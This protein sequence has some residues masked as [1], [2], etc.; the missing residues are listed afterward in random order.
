MSVAV[1]PPRERLRVAVAVVVAAV[2]RGAVVA[3]PG[4]SVEASRGGAS[5]PV[6]G[7]IVPPAPGGRA[8]EAPPALVAPPAGAAPPVSVLAVV[9]VVLLLVTPPA[10]AVVGRP[11]RPGPAAP[12][13]V[14]SP[15]RR[16]SAMVGPFLIG[17]LLILSEEKLDVADR[18]P[19][20]PAPAE[21][22]AVPR[23][24]VV[25]PR[26]LSAAVP[27]VLPLRPAMCS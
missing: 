21:G 20:P 16:A 2:G 17:P 26:P 18:P 9:V 14:V 19:R 4:R 22:R 5:P 10:G 6:E 3:P 7:G 25:S 1:G 11:V 27:A 15:G 24:A 8:V 12:P 23:R 13:V